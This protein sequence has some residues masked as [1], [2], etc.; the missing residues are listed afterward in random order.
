MATVTHF[1]YIAIKIPQTITFAL[2]HHISLF[3]SY[4]NLFKSSNSDDQS[5]SSAAVNYIL[6]LDGSPPSLLHVPVNNKHIKNSTCNNKNTYMYFSEA[7]SQTVCVHRER[8][9]LTVQQSYQRQI[10]RWGK[11]RA[12]R[13]SNNRAQPDDIFVKRFELQMS[14][15]IWGFR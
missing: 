15:S 6:I 14:W 12:K 5:P 3:L 10:P 2:S 1:L 4:I 13:I 8:D 7:L 11:K 9:E